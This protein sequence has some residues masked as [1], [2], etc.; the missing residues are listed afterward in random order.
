MK[1]VLQMHMQEPE[2][3]TERSDD[4]VVFLEPEISL[5]YSVKRPK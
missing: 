5:L 3:E 4:Y 1:I 2:T